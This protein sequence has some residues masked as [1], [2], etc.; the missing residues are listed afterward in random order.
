MTIQV[1]IQQM[2]EYLE[3]IGEVF[4]ARMFPIYHEWNDSRKGYPVPN[5]VLAVVIGEVSR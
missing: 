1:T 2:H 4:D 5:G 3:R